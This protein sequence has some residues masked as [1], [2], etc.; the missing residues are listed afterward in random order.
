MT[1]YNAVFDEKQ[2]RSITKKA[3][4]YFLENAKSADIP[5][6]ITEVPDAKQYVHVI[7]D[8]A[9]G[10]TGG[11]EWVEEGRKMNV[12]HNYEIFELPRIQGIIQ[13]RNQDIANY[14]ESLIS[15]KH[16]AEIIELVHEVDYANFHGAKDDQGYQ[17]QEGLIGMLT[18]SIDLTSADGHDCSTKGEIWH[19]IKELME[20]IP[21]EIREAGPDMI[22]WLNEITMSTAS[23]PDR[24]YN[25]KVEWDFI[26]DQFIG[27]KAVHGRK[28]GKVIIT[29]MINAEAS[30]DTDGNSAD[31]ADV[32]GTDGRIMLMVPDKRL[33]ARVVSR[34]FSLIGEEQHMLHVDQLYG[35]RGRCIPFVYGALATAGARAGVRYTEALSF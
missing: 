19:V 6:I 9:T 30:D 29:N 16:E 20:S 24:I 17:L 28:I 4:D 14:G 33:V 5:L 12:R 21:Y 3:A 2:Y 32:L 7:F 27:E 18:S 10:A 31:S 25:D 22:M 1:Y 15:D 26:Y 11:L 34:G 35:H 13:I 23:G 8:E